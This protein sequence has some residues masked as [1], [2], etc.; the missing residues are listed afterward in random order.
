[1]ESSRLMYEIYTICKRL[2]EIKFFHHEM[3][4]N[5]TEMQMMREIILVNERGGHIISSHL[6]KTLGITRSAVSQMVNKLEA[7]NVIRR[8][9]D[10]HD[11][12]IAYIELS[13]SA[14]GIY[15]DVKARVNSFLDRVVAK[16]GEDRVN[17]FLSEAN[18]FVAAFDEATKE[19]LAEERTLRQ[20]GQEPIRE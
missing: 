14:R 11:R 2:E 3:P 1:M 17:V 16:L 10:D 19:V 18:E 5:N 7:K 9:P 12:K 8:V 6:A 15:E 13:D 4:F 20:G